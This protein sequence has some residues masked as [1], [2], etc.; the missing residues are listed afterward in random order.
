MAQTL[1]DAKLVWRIGLDNAAD[2]RAWKEA[3][4]QFGHAYLYPLQPRTWHASVQ[5]TW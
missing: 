4:Y 1:G 3:P 5:T 2:R